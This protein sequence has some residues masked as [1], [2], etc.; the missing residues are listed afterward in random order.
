MF[1]VD[2]AG[3]QVGLRSLLH[4]AVDFLQSSGYKAP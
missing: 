2:E 4:V 1:F 3:M